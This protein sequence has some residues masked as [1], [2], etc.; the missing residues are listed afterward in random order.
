[1]KKFFRYFFYRVYSWQLKLWGESNS[2]QTTAN[3]AI[4]IMLF[5]NLYTIAIISQVLGIIK[6]FNE[7]SIPKLF[8]VLIGIIL[9]S[10]VSF[11]IKRNGGYTQIAKLYKDESR[12]IRN[13]KLLYIWLYI[14]A[15]FALPIFLIKLFW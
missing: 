11:W 13:L 3:G 2:P 7:E 1:M 10:T 4:T 9:Y 5:V 14:I 6:L 12:K 8:I 15:S